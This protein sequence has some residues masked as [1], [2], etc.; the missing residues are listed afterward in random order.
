MCKKFLFLLLV[1]ASCE[2]HSQEIINALTPVIGFNDSHT[3][4]IHKKTKIFPNGSQ[5]AMALVDGQQ[6]LFYGV[7]R[8]NDSLVTI[9]NSEGVFEIGSITKVFTSTL[10]AQEVLKGT[11]SLDQK[12]AELLKMEFKAGN[13]ITLKELANH[14]SGMPRLAGNLFT[15]VKDQSNP[16][17]D[18]SAEIMTNYLRD[19]L[20]LLDKKEYA[21]SN[22]GVGLLG[23]S[24]SVHFERPYTEV[25]AEKIFVPLQMQHTVFGAEN[26]GDKFVQGLNP[27]GNPTSNWDMNVHAPAGGILSTV[28]DLE[29][30][31]RAQ[32]D[33]EN[34]AMT[35]TRTAT[36]NIREDLSIGL[37]WHMRSKDENTWY[38]HSG[39]TGGYTSLL[40]VDVDNQRAVIILSNVSAF[41]LN[42]RN[43]EQLGAELLKSLY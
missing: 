19:E 36:H 34:K 6:T 31:A 37:G 8:R 13:D 2:G 28:A 15:Y 17:K 39:G 21:Y 33:P 22:T 38:A 23:H 18:Y 11:L 10:L 41:N 25:I 24:L 7:E 5:L 27:E 30:F 14:T 29:K 12:V 42:M 20:K 35:L 26:A 43:V 16:Y 32:F 9:N 4:L 1:F 40:V 3:E